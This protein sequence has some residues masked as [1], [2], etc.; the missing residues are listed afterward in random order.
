MAQIAALERLPMTLGYFRLI[1]R[2]FGADPQSRHLLLENTGVSERDLLNPAA[3]ISLFQQVQQ[4]E[5]VNALCGEGWALS[6]PELWNPTAHG[7]LGVAVLSAPTLG[8]GLIVLQR[9]SHVRAPFFHMH[10][11]SHRKNVQLS[12]ELTAELDEP[13]W[14]PMI[15]IAFIAVHAMCAAV[16]GRAPHEAQFHFACHKPAHASRLHAT[17][18]DL[19]IFGSDINK[20][21]LPQSWISM[22]SAFAD[23]S[24]FER[25]LGELE[26]ALERLE[27]PGD[28]RARLERLL[29]TMPDGRLNAADVARA[30]GVSRRTL[31]RRLQLAGTQFRNL[32]D[33]ELKSRA[34]AMLATSSLTR[35]DMAERLGYRDATSFSRACRR[36]FSQDAPK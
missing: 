31:A 9:Y 16:L 17:L 30:L 23:A 29:K 20:I 12:Y 35:A 5:N 33:A 15:E 2:V 6:Q 24:L 32:L 36:W 11:Q 7:A 26:A 13:Q 27:T 18:G 21:V 19:L 4:V 22:P 28:L 8:E 3:E 10:M 14:R 25:S 34:A 1:L